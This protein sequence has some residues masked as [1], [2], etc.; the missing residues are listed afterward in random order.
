M[1]GRQVDN[2]LQMMAAEKGAAQNTIAAYERDLQQFLEFGRFAD[3]VDLNKQS[4]ESYIRDLHSRGFAQRSI[5]RKLSAIKEFCKFLYSEKIIDDNPAQNIL[6]P[7]QEK[8]LPKFLTAD[9]LKRLIQTAAA[10]EDYRIQRIAVMIEL[11]YASGMRVSELVALPKNALNYNKGLATVLGKGSKERVIPIAEHTVKIL[12]KHKKLREDFIK[13][14]ADS[15]FLFP[16]LTAVDGHLTRDAFYKDLKTLAV[17]CGIYPSKISPHV[18]RHSFATHLLNNDADLRSVQKMLGH[19]NITTTEIY[20]HIT[21]Q[22]L[23]RSVCL[24]HPLARYGAQKE[25]E[26]GT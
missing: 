25:D 22:K 14:N 18:L 21:S 13:K 24:K 10:S 3:K 5:A 9:E 16:S 19:E 17:Q 6:S 15:P 1:F 20:T 4:I 12:E 26:D 11:M 8:S 2:F 23:M 7:K